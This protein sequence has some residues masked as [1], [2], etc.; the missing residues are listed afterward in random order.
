MVN[1]KLKYIV[2][3][4]PTATVLF[5]TYLGSPQQ[6]VSEK[7]YS[8]EL[9]SVEMPSEFDHNPYYAILDGYYINDQIEIIHNFVSK[10]LE[11]SQDLDPR[12]SKAVDKH[13]WDLV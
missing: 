9:S 1:V 12:F 13:F 6:F 8:A 10:I 3:L 5:Y 4:V 2:G 7:D 11:E